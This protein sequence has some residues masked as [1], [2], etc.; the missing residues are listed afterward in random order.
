M[1][2][3]DMIKAQVRLEPDFIEEDALLETYARAAVRYVESHTGRTLYP[4]EADAQAAGDVDALVFDGDIEAA[5]LLLV[6]HW[7]ANREAVVIDG[8]TAAVPLGVDALLSPHRH[9]HF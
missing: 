5:M 3:L 8:K 2:K 4:T 6:G 7:Y 9:Y 1:L